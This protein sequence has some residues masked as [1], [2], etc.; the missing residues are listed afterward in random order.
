MM[1][2][3]MLGAV[4][5]ARQL[6][7]RTSSSQIRELAEAIQAVGESSR[8]GSVQGLVALLHSLATEHEK[9]GHLHFAGVG[10]LDSAVATRYLGDVDAVFADAHRA[11]LLLEASSAG[12]ELLSARIEMAWVQAA[13][14]ELSGSRRELDQLLPTA[15]AFMH[16][17]ILRE[18]SLIEL[19]FGSVVRAEAFVRA[20]DTQGADDERAALHAMAAAELAL[21]Q[22]RASTASDLISG[23]ELSSLSE[24]IASKSRRLALRAR[25]A[26]ELGHADVADQAIAAVAHADRQEAILWQAYTR[27]IAAIASNDPAAQSDSIQ[28]MPLAANLLVEM[29]L[30]RC[31]SLNADAKAA[32][33]GEARRLPE[34]WLTSLRQSLD[35]SA[36]SWLSAEILSA[37]GTGEDVDNLQ[38]WEKAADTPRGGRGLAKRLARRVALR[39]TIR[40][41]GRVEIQVGERRVDGAQVRRKVLSLLCYLAAR[42]Q[43]SATRDQ[44]IDVLWPDLDPSTA[45]N[46]LHQTVYFLRRIFEPKYREDTS[47]G[48]V[49]FSSELIWLDPELVSSQ[50][51]LAWS[52]IRALPVVPTFDQVLA[53]CDAYSGPF[54]IEF[55]YE[56]WASTYRDSLHASY[57]HVVEGQIS[58]AT[59]TGE[60]DRGVLIARRALGVD[61]D[62]DGLEVSLIRLYRMAGAFA[63]AAEQYAHYAAATREL[64][65][66]DP[67]PL[68]LV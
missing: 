15:N 23:V 14:G 5:D 9:R 52:L 19:W 31:T 37:V 60:F 27:L 43:F 56:E 49:H 62:A 10:F 53:V 30:E 51:S 16:A 44:V 65:G 57:L 59:A 32:L 41:L 21:R 68:D 7:A 61:S 22:G 4:S 13:R 42:P 33:V 40:D 45:V 3:N 67:P 35:R 58:R 29:I 2:G 8:D 26:L 36:K 24:E 11:A 50:S 20:M 6:K 38:A 46:S 39:A 18:G 55:S 66:V 17:E 1:S 54:A 34:R 47:P 64:L 63:A 48:Y 25:V 12:P 28:L